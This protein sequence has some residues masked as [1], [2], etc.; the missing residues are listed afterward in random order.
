MSQPNL[1]QRSLWQLNHLN[2]QSSTKQKLKKT[3]SQISRLNATNRHIATAHRL[4]DDDEDSSFK[5]GLKNILNSYNFQLT[6]V[7]LVICDCM[8]VLGEMIIEL[9][10]MGSCKAHELLE[11][12]HGHEIVETSYENNETYSLNTT[13]GPEELSEH[14]GHEESYEHLLEHL[15]EGFHI[16]SICIL[17]LFNLDFL[18]RF[19]AFGYRYFLHL[20]VTLDFFIVFISLVLDVAFLI[21]KNFKQLLF[22][23]II[24]RLWRVL[25]ILHAIITA[26]KTPY[27]RKI[28][29]LI[30]KRRM[31]SRDLR[32]AYFYSNMLEEEIK[33]LRRFIDNL[34]FEDEDDK[35]N[36]TPANYGF[37]RVASRVSVMGNRT[38]KV[39]FADSNDYE[40]A[41][42][43]EHV[44]FDEDDDND[45]EDEEG[46][47]KTEN[48]Q[49][50]SSKNEH[51]L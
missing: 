25:R 32:K 12:H 26:I 24:L 14:H 27:E 11:S 22:L 36:Y 3:A 20:E 49:L 30:K 44:H 21:N 40:S 35:L 42:S 15:E 18:V 51:S 47:D 2:S 13:I 1:N 23:L 29:K 28:E 48:E 43:N 31:L 7:V 19:Y 5:S 34:E 46:D 33:T 41:K 38:S 10:L 45:H 16:G 9:Q 4:I 50:Q 37:K 17:L 6:L 39:N 8:L